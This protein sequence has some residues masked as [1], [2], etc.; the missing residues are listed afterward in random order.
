MKTLFAAMHEFGFGPPRHAALRW[1][2]VAFG[3]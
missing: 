3:A 1:L 2:S